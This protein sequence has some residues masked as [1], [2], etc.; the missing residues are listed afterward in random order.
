METLIKEKVAIAPELLEKNNFKE[1][2]QV[3]VHGIVKGFSMGECTVRV[4]PTTYLIPKGSNIRCK[5]SHHFNIVMYPQ[6]QSLAANAT[7]CFTLIFEGLPADCINFD[8][9][10]IIS[11]PGGFEVRGIQ[12]NEEDVYTVYL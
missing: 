6:W 7:L 8:L 9:V 4:W 1:E 3:I 2:K 11:E 12:R 5:I 10:E